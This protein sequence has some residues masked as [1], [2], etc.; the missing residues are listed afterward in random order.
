MVSINQVEFTNFKSFGGLVSI[1]LEEGFTVITGPNGSGKSNILDGILFC[2]G[3]ASSRGMR[4]ERLPDLINSSSLKNGKA[5]ETIISV[6]FNLQDWDGDQLLDED[7]FNEDEPRILPNQK[8]WTVTRKLRL[9]PGGSYVSTY[10]SDG[11]VCT[12]QQ[13]QKLL[14]CLRVDPEGSNI[15]MQGDVT[16]IVSMNNKERRILIDELAGVALFD[17][18]IEQT[19]IKLNDVLDKEEKCQIVQNELIISKEK[20][21]K[22]CEKAKLYKALKEKHSILEIQESVLQYE[23]VDKQIINLNK[24]IIDLKKKQDQFSSDI[25]KHDIGLNQLK[26][27][28]NAIQLNLKETGEDKLINIQSRIGTLENHSRELDR[29][30]LLHKDEGNRL[31]KNQNKIKE[32]R[33]LI[34]QELRSISDSSSDKE[35]KMIEVDYKEKSQALELLKRRSLDI[36]GQSGELNKKNISI[37]KEREKVTLYIK[38]MQHK[39]RNIE[40]SLLEVKVQFEELDSQLGNYKDEI[41]NLAKNKII[42]ESENKEL[43]IKYQNIEKNKM[44]LDDELDLIN[45]TKVR[46]INEQV[47]I[48]KEL[49]RVQ[50]RK[51]TLHETRGSYALRLILDAGINGI[52]GPV[53]QLGQVKDIHRVALEVAAGSRLGH[54]V[55]DNDKIAAQAINLLKSK[56]AGRLTFLPLNRLRKSDTNRDLFRNIKE[57]GF[58]AKAIDLLEFKSVYLDVFSYVFGDT[59]V[60]NNLVSARSSKLNKRLVTL[61]GEL[62]EISG[63]ITGGN[64]INRDSLYK[65]GNSCDK[66]DEKPL[67]ERLIS[68]RDSLKESDKRHEIKSKDLSEIKIKLDKNID[69][70]N[71]IQ[72]SLKLINDTICTLKDKSNNLQSRLEDLN[73]TIG[74]YTS[75]IQELD[76]VINPEEEKL[77]ALN[78]SSSFDAIENHDSNWTKM[79]TEII[80]AEEEIEAVRKR[81]ESSITFSNQIIIEKEKIN[82]RLNLLD[83]EL[84]N[85][86]NA[87]K[88]LANDHNEWRVSRDKLNKEKASLEIQKKDLEKKF[89]S[90]RRERD[91]TEIKISNLTRLKNESIWNLECA[92]REEVTKSDESKALASRLEAIKNNLPDPLPLVDNQIREAGLE[93]LQSS[94]VSLKN[95]IESLEPVNMLA[96]DELD[97][98]NI[99]LEELVNRLNV[100]SNERSELLL[101]IETVSTLR[102]EAFMKAFKEVDKYFR[103]IFALLSEG[104]GYLQLDEPNSPLDG[105][106]TLVAHPKGKSVKRLASMSGG[107]KSLTALSFLFALQHFRPS[108]FYAL[109]EVDSFLDGINVERLSKLISS[110]SSK[111]QFLVVSH[112]RPMISASTRTIGVAQARGSHTQVVG[113]PNAA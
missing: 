8:E 34:D 111:A 61:D 35:L 108:P 66:D 15:V 9:M 96:L 63:A 7:D 93:S 105:G 86:N 14:R 31:Q 37:T 62:I 84:E 5:A 92:Q 101:R 107:E 78:I 44:L 103:E 106:L 82:N 69:E 87:A 76:S 25:S 52:H 3:L 109:D 88:K 85:I 59:L 89:S 97:K 48:E 72:T 104:E 11:Q 13:I 12:L 20:L 51:E 38:P 43:R 28:L 42:L 95:R 55:V 6:R 68:I 33:N 71:S 64:I 18:R 46:L 36:A 23:H 102:Q 24:T 1:P 16:R 49:A 83:L 73:N 99:R 53:S 45:R 60:F 54:I 90:Q 57:S 58:V 112:R 75:E 26:I 91:A 113:L 80:K 4:A 22:E 56:K 27:D 32:E 21:A 67:Q 77:N 81:R 65:F 39:K 98:L 19:N 79:N 41:H 70:T 40:S 29:Q 50:S 2:L 100:L 10:S 94:L 17:N 110:Q 47:R 74:R 30:A